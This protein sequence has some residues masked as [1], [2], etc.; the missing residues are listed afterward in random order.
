VK[1][2]IIDLSPRAAQDIGL[3]AKGKGLAR[4]RVVVVRDENDARTAV[5]APRPPW[6]A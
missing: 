5:L 2:R 1:G 3:S 4:V 6:R